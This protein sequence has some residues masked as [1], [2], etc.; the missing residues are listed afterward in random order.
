MFTILA[1][2]VI[3]FINAVTIG[4]TSELR[5]SNAQLSPDGYSR[6]TVVAGGTFPGPVIRAKKGD[7]FQLNVVNNLTDNT[8]ET[9]TSVHWHGIFQNRTN[10]ADGTA[11]VTQ[12]PITSGDSFQ[13]NFNVGQ[14]AGTFWYHS[15]LSTQYCDGLRGAFILDD[16]DDP[17]RSLYD[18]DDESTIITLADWIHTSSIAA[19]PPL[20]IPPAQVATLINGKGRYQNGPA[21]PLSVITVQRGKRYRFRLIA[22]TCDSDFTFSI[23]NHTM[24]VIEADG[25]Y[26]LPHTVDSIRIY[27]GQRYSVIVHANQQVNNYWIRAVPNRGYAGFAGGLNSAIFRYVDAPPTDP[28]TLPRSA[29]PLKETDLHALYSPMAP[30][31]PFVG[32]ADVVLYLGYAFNRSTFLFTM[33]GATFLPP[34]VPVLL[35]ILSGARAAQDLLP[36]GSVYSLPSN[37][38]IEVTIPGAGLNDGGPHPFHLHGH[39]F[40]VIQSA[41]SDSYNFINPVRRDTVSTGLQGD[42]TTIRF[43]TDNEGPWFLHCHIDWHL[44]MGL[45][46]VFAEDIPDTPRNPVPEAWKDLCPIYEKYS[47][48][49]TM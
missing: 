38:V 42:N 23:D 37:K 30:G 2:S 47:S 32:G 11:F 34:T 28:T 7:K 44:K 46:I 18:V 31:K 9:S 3:P 19:L 1:L 21:I 5:I 39:A 12:C 41:G 40:S 8:M 10:W 17:H 27:P 49:N 4:P 29:S 43:V 33:N 15:H 6:S 13:Y 26:I 25:E 35:Q 14:Q 16:P 36:R 45:A 48:S 22:M 24:T 20:Q